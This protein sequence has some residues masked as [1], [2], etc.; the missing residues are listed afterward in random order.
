MA[1]PELVV[2]RFPNVGCSWSDLR[3]HIK[4]QWLRAMSWDNYGRSGWHID[5]IKPKREFHF[6]DWNEYLA[7]CHYT[8]LQPRWGWDNCSRRVGPRAERVGL[9]R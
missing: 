7:C 2:R 1:D 9:A 5:H 8:N 6:G 4:R 3:A